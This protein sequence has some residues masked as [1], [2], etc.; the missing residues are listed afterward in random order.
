M[1]D[2]PVNKEDE[3]RGL[4]AQLEGGRARLESLGK[5][6]VV[7]ESS[8]NELKGAELAVNELEKA[9]KGADI[10]VPIG[11]DTYIKA[12][13]ADT[14]SLIVG[15]GSRLSVEK[16]V[17]DAKKTLGQRMEELE[18]TFKRLQE[19]YVDLSGKLGQIN[20]SAQSLMAELQGR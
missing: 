5:Q 2:K 6:I 16:K 18:K 12:E 13:I 14:D 4:M 10:L 3:L 20:A 1:A 9:K 8:L 11:G 17:S 19:S 15:V 7:I